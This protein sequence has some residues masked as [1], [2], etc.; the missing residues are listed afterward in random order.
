MKF[1]WV[2]MKIVQLDS[3]LFILMMKSLQAVRYVQGDT[4]VCTA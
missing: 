2:I 4:R 3:G 1:K